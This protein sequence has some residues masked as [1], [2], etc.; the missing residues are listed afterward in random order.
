MHIPNAQVRGAA[1]DEFAG[2]HARATS[3]RGPLS[4][5]RA[6]AAAAAAAAAGDGA[7]VPP[8]I[9]MVFESDTAA[10][11]LFNQVCPDGS[12]SNAPTP[13]AGTNDTVTG[14]AVRLSLI[15]AWLSCT[16]S[17]FS[18]DVCMSRMPLPHMHCP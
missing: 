12:V 9:G 13:C 1:I 5:S 4:R 11:L 6:R 8:A 16:C 2:H 10:A 3:H 7:A 17:G 14:Y 15:R 18:F